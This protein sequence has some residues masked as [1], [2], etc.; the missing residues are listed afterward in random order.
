MAGIS[1]RIVHGAFV[2]ATALLLVGS[3]AS[4]CASTAAHDPAPAK[5]AQALDPVAEER[6]RILSLLAYSVVF[7]DWQEPGEAA[8]GYNIGAVLV[9]PSGEPV[10]WNLNCNN[11]LQDG[12]QHAETRLIQH[13]LREARTYNLEGFEVFTTLEPC[14]QCSGMMAMQKIR[15]AVYGQTD[16]RYGK[17]VERLAL[18]SRSIGGFEPYPRFP[19]SDR[20]RLELSERIDASASKSGQSITDWLHSAPARELFGSADRELQSFAPAHAE[21]VRLLER[22]LELRASVAA[23]MAIPTR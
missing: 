23:S 18:D 11:L 14:A 6:D 3:L 21:N 20:A 17:A 9:S 7:Q 1:S 15:R 10:A 19:T 8:R 12:T 5:V 2:C 13:W 22:A 4:S 16:E